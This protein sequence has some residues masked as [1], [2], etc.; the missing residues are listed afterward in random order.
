MLGAPI[1][2]RN[3]AILALDDSIATTIV[4]PQDVFSMTGVLFEL[5][6]GQSPVNYFNVQIVTPDG[7]PVCCYNNLLIT[8]HLSMEECCPDLIVIPAILNI[9]K[10]L[11]TNNTVID[12][13]KKMHEKDCALMAV[14]SGSLLLAA[15]GL[16]DNK[17]ATTH[18]AMANEFRKNFP[19]VVLRPDEMITDDSGLICSGGYD[20]FLDAS[21]YM[22]EKFYGAT[23]ALQCSKIFLH[24]M[25]RR[26]QAPY[27]ILSVPKDHGDEEILR[28]Q[29][30]IGNKFA[31][32]F[33]F[34]EL[35]Q[36]YGM[37]RRTLERRF[38]KATGVTLLVYQQRTRVEYAKALLESGN[39]SFDEITYKV[40]YMDNS[41]FRK[42]FI[43]YTTL[44]PREYR[45]LFS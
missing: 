32:N 16:L 1:Q 28:I 5:T 42:L 3:V 43:K 22:I 15:T 25:G 2:T 27:A 6:Q 4:G 17:V 41:F 21:I 18:W 34:D 7:K 39:S 14:C 9:E 24:N 37:S 8:P 12:W 40:G 33:D 36:K 31:D 20:S 26:S 11:S 29:E 44:R 10:T 23:V 13:L 35:A 38:K 30:E 19:A 45:S